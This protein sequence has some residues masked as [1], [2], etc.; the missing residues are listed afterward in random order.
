VFSAITVF[1]IFGFTKPPAVD[2]LSNESLS[3]MTLLMTVVVIGISV[4]E[5]RTIFSTKP[6]AE[7]AAEQKA[8]DRD[9]G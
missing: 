3:V 7:K 1:V 8:G 6:P 5:I 4:A 9:A 2:E